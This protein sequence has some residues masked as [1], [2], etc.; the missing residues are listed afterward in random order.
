MHYFFRETYICQ[1]FLVSLMITY[2]ILPRLC[3]YATNLGLFDNTNKRK[4][5]KF[6]RPLVGGIS[7][8]IGVF[9]GYLLFVP[10]QNMM[11][12]FIGMI[13]VLMIGFA[14]DFKKLAARWKLIAQTLATFTVIYFSDTILL[15]LGNILYSGPINLGIFAIPVTI[16]CV[17]GIIN[18]T[19]MI[20]G[21]D[22]LAGSISLIAFV[23]FGLVAYI[24]N[25][26]ECVLL[27]VAL[28]GA[29]IAFLRYN[30]YPSMLFMGDAGSFLIGFSMAF[31]SITITQKDNGL[32]SPVVPLLVMA[33]PIVDTFTV[34]IKRII[35]GKNP[36]SAGKDHFHHILLR[37]GLKKREVALT[38]IL[39]TAIFSCF[40]IMGTIFRIPDYYL[41]SI[42][43]IYFI[44]YF[45]T[46]FF[47]RKIFRLKSNKKRGWRYITYE[48]PAVKE[49]YMMVNVKNKRD[50]PRRNKYLS[51]SCS[52]GNNR[53][54]LYKL[55]NIGFG[56]F[57][58]KSNRLISKGESDIN[59]M[60]SENGKKVSV[61]V[62]AEVV[63]MH[64]ENGFYRYGFKFININKQQK[65]MLDS[66]MEMIGVESEKKY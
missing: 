17:V 33:V 11:G 28:S 14:D 30:W 59:F 4:V 25:Q 65:T 42:F 13:I 20:D 8:A 10:M 5:H 57:S 15:S 53:V 6:G 29:V 46:S 2:F 54:D 27:S 66:L 23:S 31:L 50:Y 16:F 60:L 52:I 61:H 37:F 51:L 45:T 35:N 43:S 49:S 9:I 55:E 41:F 26:M 39:L 58:T 34:V 63:W 18:A 1:V 22:G 40:G 48:A 12:Y 24:N 47:L 44:T 21:V 3:L 38:L 19:N 56:G 32:V 62:K 7:I 36:F 64:K